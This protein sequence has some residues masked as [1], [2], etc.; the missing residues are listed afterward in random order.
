MSLPKLMQFL[1]V[2]F[3]NL[4]GSHANFTGT[5]MDYVDYINI[6]FSDNCWSAICA[7]EHEND[8]CDSTFKCGH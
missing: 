4:T 6:T 8:S 5:C 7:R 2:F 3:C 1:R